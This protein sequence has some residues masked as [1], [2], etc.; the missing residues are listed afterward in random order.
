M[1]NPPT[2]ELESKRIARALIEEVLNR[3]E[4]HRLP[5]FIAPECEV[6]DVPI[7]GLA[8]FEE[9][10]RTFMHVYPDLQVTVEGQVAEGDL[11]VTW[12]RATG[13]HAG[14]CQGIKATHRRLRLTGVNIQR[15]REGR[16]VEHWGGANTLEALLELGI[17]Q[18][19]KR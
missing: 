19:V 6:H 14:D 10:Y 2:P 9:H 16:I 3:R 12:F 18:W 13:T 17:V 7:K 15:I 11:V 4:A 8:F 1:P 5:E